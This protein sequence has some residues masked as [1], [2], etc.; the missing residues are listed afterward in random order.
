MASTMTV[1]PA[2]PVVAQM[3]CTNR[4]EKHSGQ[5]VMAVLETVATTGTWFATTTNFIGTTPV[6]GGVQPSATPLVIL[7]IR[8]ARTATNAHIPIDVPVDSHPHVTEQT[9]AAAV[10]AEAATAQVH[11]TWPMI[12]VTLSAT[13]AALISPVA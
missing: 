8:Y 10:P 2:A 13:I 3:N 11:A 7:K 6:H 9:I 4:A 5:I 1:T 12:L